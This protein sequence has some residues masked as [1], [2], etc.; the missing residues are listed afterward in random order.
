[1]NDNTYRASAEAYY[2]ITNN[3]HEFSTDSLTSSSED[4]SNLILTGTSRSYGFICKL[5]K[6]LGD[7]TGSLTYNLSWTLEKFLA[8]NN[9]NE[10]AP[11]FD[12]R[13]EIQF[14]S[15]YALSAQWI[16]SLLCVYASGQSYL[17]IPK[18][19]STDRGKVLGASEPN[20]V[21]SYNE[22]L[23]VNGSRLPG[24]Q[25]LELSLA[26]RFAWM[27]VSGHFSLRLLNSYGLIDPFTWELHNSAVLRSAWSATFR[28][29]GLFPLYP[30]IEVMIKL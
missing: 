21:L 6:R 12:R 11:P 13:H 16:V 15:Q 19:G 29:A 18:T 23:D 20:S 8:I 5:E 10:F 22:F 25:R 4:L 26:K 30:S 27:G 24:F 3:L 9:G 14:T 7:F 28:D 2:R 17:T 1:M